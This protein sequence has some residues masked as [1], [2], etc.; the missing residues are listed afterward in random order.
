MTN[1]KFNPPNFNDAKKLLDDLFDNVKSKESLLAGGK[2]QPLGRGATAVQ[3]WRKTTVT[4]GDPRA[5]LIP[6]TLEGFKAEG[7][8]VNYEIRQLMNQYD[9]YSLVVSVDPIPQPSV[10]ISSLKCQLEFGECQLESGEKSD[11]RPIIHS[12]FPQ[13]KW[14]TVVNTGVKLDLGLDANL[15][16][17]VGVDASELTKITNLPDYDN[18]KASVGTKDK[19]KAVIVLDGLNYNFGKFNLFAQGEDNSRCYWR[20]E[21]PEIQDKST[22]KF[23]IIFKVPKGWESIDLISNV[24]IEPSIDWLNGELTD[25]IRDLPPYL[26]DVFGN[27]ERAAKKFAVGIKE[28]WI[29]IILPNS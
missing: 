25:V 16:V 13:S 6:L 2:T 8:E 12:I 7:V 19:F 1:Q 26:K 4:F 11:Q 29:K 20:M 24:W 17:R 15:D 10:L 22:V 23:N 5:K 18:F 3:R 21:R 28:E 9:F 14:Q 27:K